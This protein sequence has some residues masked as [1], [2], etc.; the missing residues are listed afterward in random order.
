MES[1]GLQH[2][3]RGDLLQ[4]AMAL[5]EVA[6]VARIPAR[7]RGHPKTQVKEGTNVRADPPVFAKSLT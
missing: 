7:Q 6:R 4:N 1:S 3:G 2:T 5:T